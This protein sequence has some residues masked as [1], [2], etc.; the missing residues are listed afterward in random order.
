M[1]PHLGRFTILQPPL[2]M[3]Y[4]RAAYAAYCG[5]RSVLLSYAA[6]RRSSDSR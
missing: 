2:P 4:R 5:A 3:R 1:N 6:S